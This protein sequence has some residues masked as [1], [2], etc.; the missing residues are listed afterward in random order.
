MS[1]NGDIVQSLGGEERTFRFGLAEHRRL[2][3][4]LGVGLSLIVQALHPYVTALQA[5]DANGAPV[6]SLDQI[7]L[8]KLLGDIRPEHIREVLFQGLWGGGMSP[9]EAAVLCRDCVEPPRGILHTAPIAY[10]VAIAALLGPD[11]EDAASGRAGGE[12]GSP[13]PTEKSGSATTASTRSATGTRRKRS[14]P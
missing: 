2:Q 11:D 13:S 4:K 5:R 6:F 3:E 9:E 8:T 10:A 12:T 1:R 7:I 14:T